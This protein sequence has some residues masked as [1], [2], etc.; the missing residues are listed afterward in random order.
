MFAEKIL[1]ATD[2][3]DLALHAAEVAALLA[4]A[5][6]RRL[7][8]L[9]VAQPHFSLAADALPAIDAQ[10]ELKR[11]LLAAQAH[12]AAVAE[13]AREDGLACEALTTIS[14]RPGLEIV[15]AAEEQGCDLIVMGAHGPAD[16]NTL[17]TGSVAQQVLAWSPIP[18]LMLRDP[19]EAA[20]PRRPGAGPA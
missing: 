14:S 11:A 9:S 10:A 20:R 5:G 7:V 8:A 18:V 12:A 6:G 4:G 15:H 19:R 1:V 3:S 17:Y 2:G 13:L 16:A